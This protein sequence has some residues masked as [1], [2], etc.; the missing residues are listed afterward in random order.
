MLF[1]FVVEGGDGGVAGAV[2]MLLMLVIGDP[3]VFGRWWVFVRVWCSMCVSGLRGS[4][5]SIS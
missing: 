3:V 2:F 4:E 1:P 5:A